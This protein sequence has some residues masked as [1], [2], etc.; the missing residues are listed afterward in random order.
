[1]YYVSLCIHSPSNLH[2]SEHT[3][4]HVKRERERKGNW[5]NAQRVNYGF[6][7]STDAM[8]KANI[9]TTIDIERSWESNEWHTRNLIFYSCHVEKNLARC[10]SCPFLRSNYI[11]RH[12]ALHIYDAEMCHFARQHV[13]V[14]LTTWRRQSRYRFILICT[15]LLGARRYVRS[16]KMCAHSSFIN[17]ESPTCVWVNS[18]SLADG[19]EE[20]W[21]EHEN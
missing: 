4:I 5:M 17:T 13:R 21:I 19:A 14:G 11:R 9:K 12:D 20:D 8:S 6:R 1:M 2:R 18:Y 3:H 7:R 16:D 15:S 10:S